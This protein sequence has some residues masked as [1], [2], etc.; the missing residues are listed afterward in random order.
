[1]YVVECIGKFQC[2]ANIYGCER[3]QLQINVQYDQKLRLKLNFF[4]E[5]R[6]TAHEELSVKKGKSFTSATSNQSGAKTHN[7]RTIC[8]QIR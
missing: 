4:V 7:L 2:M 5:Q 3:K 1:M 6:P 8:L